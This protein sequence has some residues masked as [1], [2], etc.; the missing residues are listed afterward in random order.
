MGRAGSA[1]AD[2]NPIFEP[3]EPRL[4]LSGT[5]DAE[6]VDALVGALGD[7]A[8]SPSGLSAWTGNLTDGDVL[9]RALPLISDALGTDFDPRDV[10][11]GLLPDLSGVTT[12]A[13]LEAALAVPGIDASGFTDDPDHLHFHVGFADT[14]EIASIPLDAGFDAAALDLS[15]S[16][17]LDVTVSLDFQMDVGAVWTGTEAVFYVD[18]SDETLHVDA[19]IAGSDLAAAARLGFADIQIEPSSDVALHGRFTVDLLDPGVSAAG[20]AAGHVTLGELATTPTASLVDA[21]LSHVGDAPSMG[22]DVTSSLFGGTQSVDVTWTDIADPSGINVDIDLPDL[23]DLAEIG[24]DLFTDGLGGLAGFAGIEGL[25]GGSFLGR[26]LPLIGSALATNANLGDMLS[27]VLDTISGFQTAGGLESAL[28]GLAEVAGL[29]VQLAGGDLIYEFAYT[30]SDTV[31]VPFDLGIGETFALAIEGDVELAYELSAAIAV[32]VDLDAREFFFQVSDTDPEVALSASVTVSIDHAEASVGF[33][34]VEVD[35]ATGTLEAEISAELTPSGGRLSLSDLASGSVGDIIDVEFTGSAEASLPLTATMLPGVGGSRTLTVSWPDLRDTSSLTHN[36]DEFLDFDSFSD[37]TGELFANGVSSLTSLGGVIQTLQFLSDTLA[38]LGVDLGEYLNFEEFLGVN[39]LDEL[40]EFESPGEG[41]PPVQQLLFNNS[42]RLLELLQVIDPDATGEIVE[43]DPGE[44]VYGLEYTLGFERTYTH[45]IDALDF[46]MGE[47]GIGFDLEVGASLELAVGAELTFGVRTDDMSF[48]LVDA[49]EPELYATALVNGTVDASAT[50]GFLEVGIDGGGAY[51]YSGEGED[52][53][54]PA[55]IALS[56]TDPALDSPG[57]GNEDD[58][59]ITFHE[60]THNAL[61]DLVEHEFVAGVAA[62]LPLSAGAPFDALLADEPVLS[63]TW[64]DLFDPSSIEITNP[65]DVEAFTNFSSFSP[66]LILDGLAE[67]IELI[68]DWTGSDILGFELPLIGASLSDVIDFASTLADFMGGFDGEG[69]FG[70]I[71]DFIDVLGISTDDVELTD[72]DIRFTVGFSEDYGAT[73][74]D[75]GL[76]HGMD[77]G[78]GE[79]FGLELNGDIHLNASFSSALT[80]GIRF[81]ELNPLEAVFL[82]PDEPGDLPEDLP[83]AVTFGIDG[84]ISGSAGALGMLNLEAAGTAALFREIGMEDEPASVGLRITDGD[85]DGVVTMSELFANPLGVIDLDGPTGAATVNLEL[86]AEILGEPHTATLD[87]EWADILDLDSITVNTEENFSELFDS[88]VD[89]E[90]DWNTAIAAVGAI[91]EWLLDVAGV[92]IFDQEI[93]LINQSLNELFGGNFLDDVVG[94][95]QDLEAQLSGGGIDTSALFNDAVDALADTWGLPLDIDLLSGGGFEFAFDIDESFNFLSEELTWDLGGSAGGLNVDVDFDVGIDLALDL[96]F[97]YT[98]DDGFYIV[99]YPGD[100]LSLTAAATATLNDVG[101][102]FLIVGFR[103]GGTDATGREGIAALRGGVT[104]GLEDPRGEGRVSIGELTSRFNEVVD[105]DPALEMEVYLPLEVYLGEPGNEDWPSF[106]SAFEMWW[107]PLDDRRVVFGPWADRSHEV[108]DAFV[109]ERDDTRIT[110]ID[111]GDAIG[112]VV[113]PVLEFFNDYYPVPEQVSDFLGTNIPMLDMTIAEVL[114]LPQWANL[115]LS[116]LPMVLSWFD[117]PEP[118]NPLPPRSW[119]EIKEDLEED[120]GLSFPILEPSNLI[121]LM[122]GEDV[123]LVV[124]D[125]EPLELTERFGLDV[126]LLSYGIPFLGSISLN[127]YVEG[128]VTLGLDVS[129]GLD[130]YG[131]RKILD[132]GEW[133]DFFDGFWLGDN[134]RDGRDHAEIYIEAGIVAGIKGK[135]DLLGFIGVELYGGVGIEGGIGL[136]LNDADIETGTLLNT[137]T[138]TT[139]GLAGDNKIHLDE[140]GWIVTN[141]GWWCLFNLSGW[142]DLLFEVGFKIDLVLFSI[143]R[144]KQWEIRLVDFTIGCSQDDTL[145]MATV[146]G[147]VVTLAGPE[148]PPAAPAGGDP[149]P[150]GGPTAP[151]DDLR[152]GTDEPHIYRLDREELDDGTEVLEIVREDPGDTPNRRTQQIPLAD[153]DEIEID[154]GGGDD[155]LY[156]SEELTGISRISVHGGDGNDIIEVPRLTDGSLAEVTVYGDAGDDLIVIDRNG[157]EDAGLPVLAGFTCTLDGGDGADEIYGPKAESV[158]IYGGPGDDEL[159]GSEGVDTIYGMGGDDTL[160]GKQGDDWLYGDDDETTGT[161]ADLIYGDAGNDHIYGAGGDDTIFSGVTD[162]AELGVTDD[163]VVHGGA[164]G[165]AIEGGDGADEIHGDA[166]VDRLLG[167]TGDD[168]IDGGSGGDEI[169]GGEGADTIDGGDGRDTINGEA[170]DD[171]IHG[172]AGDDRIYGNA[173]GDTV[174]GDDGDDDIFGGDNDDGAGEIDELHGGDGRDTIDGGPGV[175]HLY[176]DG[177]DDILSGA[178]GADVLYGGAGDDDIH[179]GS[180]ADELHGQAGAD[181][182]AGDGDADE[183]F[184]EGGDDDLYGGTGDDLLAGGAGADTVRGQD[185]ADELHGHTPDGAGDDNAHDTLYGGAG[186]D[187]LFGNGGP[188]TLHGEADDDVLHGGDG[189]DAMYGE[190]G[191]DRLYGG[192]GGDAMDGGAGDDALHGEAGDDQMWG[193]AGADV[194]FGGA[195]ADTLAGDAGSDTTFDAEAPGDRADLLYG[196]DDGDILYGNGGADRIHGQ[197]GSD[198]AYAGSGADWLD[199]GA[200]A[201]ALHGQAGDDALHAGS[202]DGDSLDGGDGDDVLTGSDLGAD[203]LRGGAGDDLLYG[204]GGGDTIEGGPGEDL[205]YAGLGDDTLIG[206]EGADELHGGPGDDEFHGHH[207]SYGPGAEGESADRLFGDAG[208]DVFYAHGGD[209]EVYGGAGA[210]VAYGGV[211]SDLLAGGPGGDVLYGEAGDD[212]LHADTGGA[213]ADLLYGGAGRD[214]LHG[215]P[216]GD[217]LYGEGGS[218]RL[219]GAGGD[220]LLYGGAGADELHGGP[221]ADELHGENGADL[222]V[223]GAGGDFLYG[224]GGSDPDDGAADVL[225]GDAGSNDES[226]SA[227]ADLLYGHGGPDRIY[228]EGGGDA[229]YGGLGD[230]HIEAGAG[231]DQ[232]AGDTV[233]GDVSDPGDGNDRIWAGAGDDTVYGNGGDDFARGGDGTDTGYEGDGTDDFAEFEPGPPAGGDEGGSGDGPG[234]PA[235][236]DAPEPADDHAAATLPVG[237]EL[238]GRWAELAWSATGAGLSGHAAMSV[239]PAAVLDASGRPVVA[240][241]DARNGNFEI[242]L[243]RWNGSAWEELA[244]SAGGGGVSDTPGSSRAPAVAADATG[245]VILAWR[246]TAADGTGEVYLRRWNGTAWEQLAGS[247]GGGGVSGTGGATD[248][249]ALAVRSDGNPAVAWTDGSAGNPEVYVRVWDGAAWA[250]L[251]GSGS[252]GG[253]SG[254]PGAASRQPAL[255][256][257]GMD[258]AAAWAEGPG[259]SREVYLRRWQDAGSVWQ[260]IAGSGSG[261]GVS[262][263]ATDSRE[264]TV[265]YDGDGDI[266]LAWTDGTAAEATIRVAAQRVG[267]WGD[268][269]AGS[270]ADGVS[271]P[272]GLAERPAL[273]V[274]ADGTV[275][276]AWLE[277]RL[278]SLTGDNVDVYV[279]RWDAGEQTWA[280]ELPGDASFGGVSRN[281]GDA[282]ALALA[283][284]DSG[285]PLAAW[286]D[287]TPV[288]EGLAGPEVFVRYDTFDVANVYYVNLAGDADLADN[289]FT[290][291]AGSAGNT[292]TAADSP[293][294]DIAAVYAAHTPGP[295]DVVLVDTGTYDGQTVLTDAGALILGSPNGTVLTYTGGAGPAVQVDGADDLVLDNLRFDGEGLEVSDA[296]DAAENVSV[297]HCSFAGDDTA[298]LVRAVG[299]A[300][301]TVAHCDFIGGDTALGLVDPAG[302]VLHGN[303]L[304]DPVTGVAATGASATGLLIEAGRI[305]GAGTGIV[306]DASAGDGH[307]RDNRL[308]GCGTGIRVAAAMGGAGLTGNTVSG[309]AVALH[310]QAAAKVQGNAFG[311]A[312]VGVLAELDFGTHGETAGNVIHDNATGIESA[313]LV[314]LQTVRDN[315]LGIDAAGPVG[316]TTHDLANDIHGNDVGVRSGGTVRFNRIHDNAR[317]VE[318]LDGAWI[319]ENVIW[320]NAECGVL[321]DGV[322]GVTLRNNTIDAAGGDAARL[323][324]GASNVA[325]VGNILFARDGYCIHV[326]NDSQDGFRSDYNDLHAA[327]AGALVWWTRPFDDL[328]DWQEDVWAHDF[329]SIGRTDPNPA[330]SDPRFV[331]PARGDF[332]VA[333]P[334]GGQLPSSPTLGRG[335]PLMDFHLRPW[336]YPN[337]LASPGFEAGTGDWTTNLAAGTRSADPA[338]QEGSAYFYAGDVTEGFAEQTMDL[339]AAGLAEADLD[340]GRVHVSFG[341]WLRSAAENPADA[342]RIE[343]TFRDDGGSAIGSAVVLAGDN[344]SGEWQLLED[345]VACPSGTRSVRYRFVATRNEEP[346]NNAYLDGAFVC[347]AAERDLPNQGAW[348]N[349][350]GSVTPPAQSIRLTFPMLYTDW[351]HGKPREITWRTDGN[352]GDSAVR[353]ELWQD[354][355][356]GPAYLLTIAET[357]VDDGRHM[358]IPQDDSGIEAGTHGL[359]VELRLVDA[360]WVWDRSV[361]PFST[362]EETDTFYVDDGADDLDEYT[363]AATGDNRNTGRLETAPKPNPLN[364]LRIY[365]IAAGDT[366]YVDA[367]SYPLLRTVTLSGEVS[368]ADDEGFLMTGPAGAGVA[369]YTPAIPHND[370]QDLIALQDGDLVEIEHLRLSGGRHGVYADNDSL[371][372]AL[373]DVVAADNA[374]SGL[375]VTGGSSVAEVDGFETFGHDGPDDCGLLIDGGPGGVLRNVEA[376]G[377]TRGV[378]VWGA[379]EI[380]LVDVAAHDNTETGIYLR[381]GQIDA[382]DLAAWSHPGQV[383]IYAEDTASGERGLLTDPVAYGNETGIELRGS[384]DLTGG[385]AY[386]NAAEGVLLYRYHFQTVDG[387]EAYGNRDGV[388]IGEGD[389]LNAHVHDNSRYGVHAWDDG[390]NVRD[391]RIEGNQIGVYAT[392]PSGGTELTNNLI[393]ANDADGVLLD[394]AMRSGGSVLL[395][396]NTVYEPGGNAVRAVWTTRNVHLRNNILVAGGFCVSMAT[397]AQAGF[398]SN[399]NLFHPVGSGAVGV[400]QGTRATLSDWRFATFQDAD[401]LADDPLFVDAPGGDFHLASEHGSYHG[402]AWTPDGVTSPALDRADAADAFGAES[403]PNGGYRNLGAYGNTPEAS[404]SPEQF[405]TVLRPNGGENWP[406]ETDQTVKWRSNGFAGTVDVHYSPDGGATWEPLALDADN[407]DAWT[408]SNILAPVADTYLVRVRSHDAPAL[409]DTSDATFRVTE[410]IHYYYVDDA[411]DVGDVYTPGA[412]GDDTN[413]GRTPADPKASIMSVLAEYDVGP[414]D[415]IFVDTGDYAVTT[416]IQLGYEHSGVTIVGPSTGSQAAVLDRGST[417][418]GSYVFE[419][420]DAHYVTIKYIEITGAAT[421]IHVD[422]GSTHLTLDANVVQD[423][424]SFGLYVADGASEDLLLVNNTFHGVD[425]QGTGVRSFA[426]SAVVRN[427]TAGREGS[428]NYGLYFTDLDTGEFTGNTVY[429]HSSYGLYVTG[430]QYTISGTTAY[431]CGMGIRVDD[432]HSG[433]S[434]QVYGNTAYDNGTGIRTDGGDEIFDNDVHDN[435]TGVYAVYYGYSIIRDNDVYL[436]NVG[437]DC[438]EGLVSGNRVRGNDQRGI[439]LRSDTIEVVGNVVY[440]NGQGVRIESVDEPVTLTGNLVYNNRSGGIVIVAGGY[441]DLVDVRGNTVY[442]IWDDAVQVAGDSRNVH[443]G[444]NILYSQ[445][446]YELRVADDSQQD[447]A[448]DYNLFQYGGGP[449]GRMLHWQQPWTNLTDW[450]L[451]LGFDANS[452]VVA[453]AGFVDADGADG[454]LG[455]VMPGLHGRYYDNGNLMGSPVLERLDR[456][457]DFYWST[458]DLPPDPLLLE[459]FSVSWEGWLNV[460]AADE[461]QIYIDSNDGGRLYLD[462]GLLIDA[463]GEAGEFTTRDEEN[464]KDPVFLSAGWHEIRYEMHNGGSLAEGRIRWETDTLS[465]RIIPGRYFSP[466]PYDGDYGDDDN[467]HL[468]STHGSYLDDETWVVGGWDSPG[469]DAGDPS[470]AYG[471]EPVPN[472]DRVNLGAYGN[473]GQ[474]SKSPET[475]IQVLSPNGSEKFR[476]GEGLILEWRSGGVG[477]WV[478]VYFRDEGGFRLVAEDVWNDGTFAWEPD[479]ATGVGQFRVVDADHPAVRDD[480]DG[481]FVVGPAGHDYYVN[482]A[483]D[484]D[485]DD[486]EWTTAAGDNTHSG[487]AP[488]EPMASLRALLAAYDLGAGD[489][490]HVDTGRYDLVAPVEIGAADAG[491]TIRGPADHV[492]VL[493]RANVDSNTISLEDADGV[494]LRDLYVTGAYNGIR[495]AGGSSN[496]RLESVT[497][498]DNSHVGVLI[499]GA[500][501]E[502]AEIVDCICYGTVGSGS[503]DQNYGVRVYGRYATVRDSGLFHVGG[504]MGTGVSLENSAVGGVVTGNDLHDNQRGV[505]A[506]N[507]QFEVAD[508]D[509]HDNTI[510]MDLTDTSPEAYSPVHGNEVHANGTGIDTNGYEDTYNNVVHDNAGDGISVHRYSWHVVRDNDVY[511]NGDDGIDLGTGEARDNR[512]WGNADAGIVVASERAEVEGNVVYGNDRGIYMPVYD[513]TA[514]VRGNLVYD[515]ASTGI[516]LDGAARGGEGVLLVNN[517]V[518]QP[519]GDAV[520]VAGGSRLVELRNNILSAGGYELYV[521]DD[522]QAGFASDY[523]LFVDGGGEVRLH[524]QRDFTSLIDWFLELGHDGESLAAAD[525]MFVDPDGPDDLWGFD[526]GTGTDNGA[527]DD[528][529]L[530]SVTGSH[531]GGAW[532]PDPADSPGLDAGAPGDAFADEPDPD[533]GRVNVGAYG[534]TVQ[535]SKSPHPYIQ[536]TAPNGSEKLTLHGG[537]IITWR[538]AGAGP[539]VDVLFSPDGGGTWTPLATGIANDGDAPWNPDVVTN[540]GLIRVVDAADPAVEGRSA[541]VFV[542][543]PT[544][545]DYYVNIPGDADL[546]DNEYT[547]AAGDNTLSGKTPDEPM[548]SLR[549]LLAA[550]DLGP[551]DTVWVDTG[552]YHLVAPVE[553]GAGDMGVTI[554]GPVE[555]GHDATLDRGN[556]ASQVMSLD[557]AHAVT[558]GD[559]HLTGGLHGVEVRGGSQ[560]VTIESVR[561]YDNASKGVYISDAACHYATVRDSVLYGTTGDESTDQ[562]RGIDARGRHPTITGNLAY[563]TPGRSG[564]GIFVHDTS[565]ATVTGNEAYNCATGVHVHAAGSFTVADNVAHDCTTG[566][567]THDNGSAVY[568]AVH[569]NEAYDNVTGMETAGY[570]EL[571]DNEAHHNSSVGIELG[572][573]NTHVVR[574]NEVHH[575]AT[576]ILLGRGTVEHNRVYVNSTYG[577]RLSK[578]GGTVRD[579]AVYGNDRG[580]QDDHYYWAAEIAGNLVYDNENYGVVLTGTASQNDGTTVVNNTIAQDVGAAL[581]LTTTRP[582]T[583]Q[584]NILWIE[585]GSGIEVDAAATGAYAG[586]YNDIFP[587]V[588]GAQVGT[589]AG[590]AQATLADWRAAS[591]QDAHSFSADPGFIDPDGADNLYGWEGHPTNADGGADDNFHLAGGAPV[592]DAAYS[593]AAPVADRDGLLRVDDLG[594]PNTGAGIFRYVDIGCYE[595]QGSTND[596]TPPQVDFISPA[597]ADGEKTATAFTSLTVWF[598][599]RMDFTSATSPANYELLASGGDGVFGDGGEVEVD[600]AIDYVFGE[601]SLE[602]TWGGDL[603][604]SDTYRLT[605]HGGASR[606]LAD[607][608]G[609]KLDGDYD[610]NPGGDW[611]LTFT[612]DYDAPVVDHIVPAGAV[613]AGPDA[614]DVVFHDSDALEPAGVEDLAAY[615]LLH[616][617]GDDV[618]DDGDDAD[619]SASITAVAYDPGTMTATLTLDAPLPAERYRLIVHAAGIADEVGHV[620]NGGVDQ[621]FELLVD[622][623]P[624]AGVLLEPVPGEPTSADAGYVDVRWSDAD[625]VGIDPASLDA[626][627]VTIASPA[628]VTV[629]RAEVLP[630]RVRY[631][632]DDDGDALAE[633]AVTVTF[634]AGEVADLAGNAN[635]GGSAEFVYDATGPTVTDVTA[636]DAGGL[637]TELRIDFDE[638]LDAATATDAANYALLSS[639]G[640]GTFEDGDEVDQSARIDA[641][642]YDPGLARVTLHLAPGLA[643]EVYQLTVAGTATVRDLAGNALNDGADEVRLITV[644]LAGGAATVEL[645]PD[646]DTNIV[647]D[648]ITALTDVR[649]LLAADEAGLLEADYDNDGTWD[650]AFDVGEGGGAFEVAHSFPGDGSH[651]VVA[652]LTDTG[653]GEATG[654]A[655]ILVDTV[656]P[657]VDAFSPEIHIVPVTFTEPPD[658]AAAEDAANY[659]LLWAGPDG[660]LD[661]GGDDVPIVITVAHAP[662]GPTVDITPHDGGDFPEGLFRIIVRTAPG[663]I[664]VAGNDLNEGAGDYTAE[665]TL[666]D[667]PPTVLA[668]S[669][670]PGEAVGT[671]PAYIELIFSEDID[672]AT[673]GVG[674]LAFGG[675]A[676]ATT[677]LGVDAVDPATYRFNICPACGTNWAEGTVTVALVAGAVASPSGQPNEAHD[678]GFEYDPTAPQVTALTMNHAG[679]LIS[680]MLSMHATFTEPVTC[681]AAAL[682]LTNANTG[683]DADLAAAVMHHTPETDSVWWD[684]APAGVAPGYYYAALAAAGVTDGANALDGD[685]DGS[686]GGDYAEVF[687]VR[688]PGDAN[689]DDRVNARDYITYKRNRGS[690]DTWAKADFDASGTADAADLAA[691]RAHMGQSIGPAPAPPAP[692][693]VPA[694]DGDQPADAPAPPAPAAQETQTPQPVAPAETDAQ[695]DPSPEPVAPLA[696]PAADSAVT[697]AP[698][699]PADAAVPADTADPAPTEADAVSLAGEA[700]A[701]PLA[702]RTP[703]PPLQAVDAASADPPIA[704]PAPVPSSSTPARPADPAGPDPSQPDGQPLAMADDLES[705]A[706]QSG[707]AAALPA[708]TDPLDPLAAARPVLTVL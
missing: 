241:A 131:L 400:W 406:Q 689:L 234:S 606:F 707:D 99:D 252:G 283:V 60:L 572:E 636:H 372:L 34:G 89:L 87:L 570:E 251:A 130:T 136:D 706:E 70:S 523:N 346:G 382:T 371:S 478:D 98:K 416:N 432:M 143:D 534:G 164:G 509:V 440:G 305:S 222:L 262:D 632:Y 235:P 562:E 197:A 604:P 200:G 466:V 13:E 451:E 550:Y 76:S 490:V 216:D 112:G 610:D 590:A 329:N 601:L 692:A 163:D 83:L 526:E 546:D 568:S 142:I 598:T 456:N 285:H 608:A 46:S 299:T 633:G 554:R 313:G 654:D 12:L 288:A 162:A 290:A 422:N 589:W 115:L 248:G 361:E 398:V 318:A 63:L 24:A 612:V 403:E 308:T 253:V 492:A 690:G 670:A 629:D 651:T 194:L 678:W 553:I 356:E 108:L 498:Y 537:T 621:A 387:V 412:T 359:R 48:Y 327:G 529:H 626:A 567:Y 646:D 307:I 655:T 599:E 395:M 230:D 411:A 656:A 497:A 446:R 132:G 477:P 214:V 495:I 36:L 249:P 84:A 469:I 578:Y 100:E 281:A 250:E 650:A 189:S 518:D 428:G 199:G 357:T 415:I 348:G 625:G 20:E 228:G 146:E 402:G 485:F 335:D 665:F 185:G 386:D 379:S 161:G 602:L 467:F 193:G 592:I 694:A 669:P 304:A 494:T 276:L 596:Q 342:G 505:N 573:G 642:D 624:P 603:L 373:R 166:G 627:D 273:A 324:G 179:G 62:E 530:R 289:A 343:L 476:Q 210:D 616:T 506:Y 547:T 586:D 245:N 81:G 192:T 442:E 326:A 90:F 118:G 53:S 681:D 79:I 33:L 704:Q 92:E 457:V 37:M 19:T 462:G 138:D 91:I 38:L 168:T 532:T 702:D 369:E 232:I 134:H 217:Q 80:W 700:H 127:L 659:E 339:V 663:I 585:G 474:A 45:A 613:P 615:T 184:G 55:R 515:N 464:E 137:T 438:G 220:D 597:L 39:L 209:D 588:G 409:A 139:G 167:G 303:S 95:F 437:I 352:E 242:Y 18:A 10:L 263:N 121:M 367:G 231:G 381:A 58:G 631:W 259:A 524:W 272:G 257:D 519:V 279:R 430:D 240:W 82:V 401:S 322:D 611:T 527:D 274:G 533:G 484:T 302:G 493:D 196:G 584:N 450:F 483:G 695:G 266:V 424:A 640:D 239:E 160:A 314:Q 40:Q 360:P 147:G 531:H 703:A 582:A 413:T 556:A 128:Y 520:V 375:V 666:D 265:A 150:D 284:D 418:G 443:L 186:M 705:P 517:T 85:G 54:D 110:Y 32:G 458:Y 224:Q 513:D 408:W 321:V 383:G 21:D 682:V 113:G 17:S 459:D 1:C 672:P 688:L 47:M 316:A 190:G 687:V 691:I 488:D 374:G 479:V 595:F 57:G 676:V 639:G 3:L 275:A 336:A 461:Y 78:A 421:G 558:V 504:V 405:L 701:V 668:V 429:G 293:L 282:I 609:N 42:D 630:D 205:A 61:G 227:G 170:G 67:L 72:D 43:I 370:E 5:H 211:G 496:V 698:A 148:E 358:W 649:L 542:V 407:T 366:L 362:P 380:T 557:G 404:R 465:K 135:A 226:P 106:H 219:L 175:D 198:T 543:A 448:S 468:V 107:K 564:E 312:D 645:H 101:G 673:V 489:V 591:G 9:G 109:M 7:S 660:V 243:A 618:F 500:D 117:T 581:Y 187:V 507:G 460:P 487:L 195:G 431:D 74:V 455:Y 317:G 330:W 522:S 202:G 566:I 521:A 368:I 2:R 103:V 301:L 124:W 31:D 667:S 104:M 587:A 182:L 393:L 233:M 306:W 30:R 427:N 292:G 351:E 25:F 697:A 287:T 159:S 203:T 183:L 470:S 208:A 501:S 675:S 277:N 385:Q 149:P 320:G 453:N 390:F 399:H 291:A 68:S 66:G 51:F 662:G 218:D 333:D 607:V 426:A 394:G 579:N 261:G 125:P 331:D 15:F 297:L 244:G 223:G 561:A 50:L 680:E 560:Y 340:A 201:D 433:A 473:T 237:A 679:G 41:L 86:T 575:N 154:L 644:D 256:A 574:D 323:T 447:F 425:S 94:F 652:R 96:G 538:T 536:V 528:Y 622:G 155:E 512:V 486:N 344:G 637:A 102:H 298:A 436:N 145:T 140:L 671:I 417:L 71:Q 93:P 105:V 181:T 173:G 576:G 514:T 236:P 165:D 384:V 638:P 114:D 206:G 503:T 8:A 391:S 153:V 176:G 158:T 593:D 151:G 434:S 191:R 696:G 480:S 686:A 376:Y 583:V 535:A 353:I 565:T 541:N 544:G 364:I 332:G 643:D 260:E 337:L 14:Y 264:P 563:H 658:H 177:D 270:R 267:V 419:L 439:V 510:G 334:I 363:P 77:N 552:W 338:P 620:L 4:L 677:V 22:L 28:A 295:G 619:V 545:E 75:F 238:A 378:R 388:S 605:L 347:A 229:I 641:I 684:L 6:I 328:L 653:G 693:A 52:T 664:D 481:T 435:G 600:L 188:D 27:D 225:V 548:A 269:G 64:P 310:Y 580:I 296:G 349:V 577:I 247:G 157:N 634:V 472:G 525:A 377:N 441:E 23:A 221:G 569:G 129:L 97:G 594:T 449:G 59:R 49:A 180:G 516:E 174:F 559:L 475:Y 551:G 414:G 255:A 674:D 11:D 661:A 300:G 44:N 69:D 171:E 508:N 280:E 35:D 482:I 392:A 286:T 635:A 444:D 88:L 16:G 152:A 699:Q 423:N 56:L 571:Y 499:A 628:A 325:V 207:L 454:V 355:P 345:L 212:R 491:V 410:A 614:I 141:E 471:L 213:V 172:G 463:W 278:V 657:L 271:T 133:T 685:G 708:G 319:H 122:M 294:P 169:Y 502:Y 29:D 258:L 350:A 511:R 26:S 396:N 420:D 111:L 539:L 341:G 204:L 452:Q 647:G 365:T 178:A 540:Q 116:D 354:T 549:A 648:N 555:V 623:L 73:P 215:G 126:P 268:M 119:S 389:L 246:E 156:V 309:G 315:T 311:G 120:Y 445:N 123:D 254:T 144:N 65:I 617:G 397:D 683:L